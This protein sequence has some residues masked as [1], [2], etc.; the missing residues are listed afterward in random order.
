[1]GR[2]LATPA[3]KGQKEI[4]IHPK[5]GRLIKQVK[6]RMEQRVRTSLGANS[7]DLSVLEGEDI[8][9]PALQGRET[10]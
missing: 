1:M 6:R 9:K 2:N 10:R 8:G 3:L 7:C 5:D 4:H